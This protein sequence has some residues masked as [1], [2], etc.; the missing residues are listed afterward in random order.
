MVPGPVFSSKQHKNHKLF[1]MKYRDIIKKI[2]NPFHAMRRG[3]EK[4][5]NDVENDYLKK[6]IQLLENLLEE[7]TN[8][9]DDAK[10]IFLRNLYHEIRTP[11]NAIVGFSDLIELN[12]LEKNEKEQYI[13]YIRESSK[14]FLRKMDNIIEASILEAGLVKITMNECRLNGLLDELHT[15]FTI[16]GHIA[17]KTIDFSVDKPEFKKEINVYCDSGRLSQVL[18]NLIS[19]AFKFTNEGSIKLGYEINGNDIQFFVSDTGIGGLE[20]KSHIIFNKFTKLD[21]SDN[22]QEG[23]GLGLSLSK[24]LVELMGGNLWYES[25]G[26]EGTTFYFTIPY[27]PVLTSKKEGKE[28]NNSLFRNSLK[29][30][31]RNSVAL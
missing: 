19:N 21:E 28:T 11:L 24:K 18:V 29:Q 2:T 23:L 9:V 15:Y 8:C 30:K 20:G 3:E 6:R 7:K 5:G 25:E 26:S 13:K 31:M 12:S 27:K 4:R 22:S 17:E 10:S 14:D 1:L 16:Q